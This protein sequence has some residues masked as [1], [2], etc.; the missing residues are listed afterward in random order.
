V[1]WR[2]NFADEFHSLTPERTAYFLA[3]AGAATTEIA[4]A[5]A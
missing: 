1:S 5:S 2:V 4:T 3:L